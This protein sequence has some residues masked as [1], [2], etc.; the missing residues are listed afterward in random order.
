MKNAFQAQP[1]GTFPLPGKLSW[2]TPTAHRARP[3]CPRQWGPTARIGGST[4]QVS[5]GLPTDHFGPPRPLTG[6]R[7]LCSEAG[8]GKVD[9]CVELLR[10]SIRI[11][12]F[13]AVKA[14]LPRCNVSRI[15][16]DLAAAGAVN[17]LCVRLTDAC[18]SRILTELDAAQIF[19]RNR[20]TV[21]EL[22]AAIKDAT[23]VAIPPC[24]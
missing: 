20:S 5:A 14:F 17:V 23:R 10:A 13:Q 1:F 15:P 4:V 6:G 3:D 2:P 19:S 7:F 11:A 16:A 18:W 24:P 21:E 9:R 22:H 8:T 12:T